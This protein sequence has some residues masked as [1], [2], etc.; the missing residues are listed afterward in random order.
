MGNIEAIAPGN[1]ETL[2]RLIPALIF[3]GLIGLE[4]QAHGRPAPGPS[5]HSRASLA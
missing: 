4:R 2:F 5:T 3:G 1:C